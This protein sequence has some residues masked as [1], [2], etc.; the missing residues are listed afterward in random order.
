MNPLPCVVS[1]ISCNFATAANVSI[2]SVCQ[3]TA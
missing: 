2:I 1:K 3:I